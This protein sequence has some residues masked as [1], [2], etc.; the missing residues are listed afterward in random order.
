MAGLVTFS[1]DYGYADEFVGVCK[2][3][4]AKIAP[5]VRVIDVV[6]GIRGIRSGG[7]ILAQSLPEGPTAADVDGVVVHLVVV[8]PEVG[9]DRRGV[10]VVCENGSMLV[11]PDNG[12]F[13]PVADIFGGPVAANELTEP[14]FRREDVSYT[15]HGRDIFAP[16]AAHLALGR[17]PTE[18]GPKVDPDDLVRVQPP[19]VARDK[20]V[21]QA[22]VIRDDWFGNIQLAA[23]RVDL[24]AAGLSGQV[25]VNRYEATI[26]EKF[27]DVD[28]GQ[29][30]VYVNS[31]GQL[32]I[33]RN[34]ASAVEVLGEPEWV[35]IESP[36]DVPPAS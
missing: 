16:A 36:D 27:A 12:V 14:W 25:R 30:I 21:I 9:T 7:A 17:K 1:T 5:N 24:E 4:I 31:A 13:F 8:D 3:I 2:L 11:G 19:Y 18:F 20:G 35:S 33:A 23:T 6:H 34:R 26:A 29:M 22:E 10:V 28:E 15:F 32:A